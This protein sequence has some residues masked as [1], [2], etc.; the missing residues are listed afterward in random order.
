M[1]LVVVF[2]AIAVVVVPALYPGLYALPDQNKTKKKECSKKPRTRAGRQGPCSQNGFLYTANKRLARAAGVSEGSSLCLYHRDEATRQD[3]RCSFPFTLI[4]SRTLV[5][6][7]ERLFEVIDS[8]A[9]EIEGYQP[10]TKWCTSCRKHGEE[11]LKEK[12]PTLYVPPTKRKVN[13]VISLQNF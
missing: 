11:I 12:D 8:L 10:G 2:L 4:H 1:K 7:P 13:L 6:V 3:S 5:N 9:M